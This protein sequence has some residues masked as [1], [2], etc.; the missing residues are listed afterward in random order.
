MSLAVLA[1]ALAR[2]EHKLDLALTRLAFLDST[3]Y[4]PVNTVG[5]PCPV[6][7]QVIDYTMDIH[8]GVVIRR[9]GCKSGKLPPH[10]P[11]FPLPGANNGNT[12]ST[13]S[14]SAA[15]SGGGESTDSSRRKEG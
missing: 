8:N 1:E 2:V 10:I 7:N 9:C 6:C 14:S 15:G 12:T 5:F 11:L 13:Q 3:P 4:Q